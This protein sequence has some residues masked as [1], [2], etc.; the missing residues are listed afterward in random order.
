MQFLIDIGFSLCYWVLSN[1]ES[2]SWN[3][4]ALHKPG[5]IQEYFSF[6]KRNLSVAGTGEMRLNN[7]QYHMQSAT[8]PS[9]GLLQSGNTFSEVQLFHRKSLMPS[10][11]TPM[12]ISTISISRNMLSIHRLRNGSKLENYTSLLSST[13]TQVI[14]CDISAFGNIVER[15]WTLILLCWSPWIC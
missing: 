10:H 6:G 11:P 1:D 9:H 13:R 7:M 8:Y 14:S 15:I 5:R 4:R 12:S 2:R 3:I